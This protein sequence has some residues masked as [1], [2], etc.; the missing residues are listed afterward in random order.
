[1]AFKGDARI[2]ELLLD[3]GA[4]VDGAGRDR[5]TALMY[6]AMFSQLPGI[7]LLLARGA[8]PALQ[9]AEGRTALDYARA[10]GAQVAAGR[11]EKLTG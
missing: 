6:A 1:M 5:K 9:D 7:E 3:H 8:S 10:M 11:L 4:R 2:A